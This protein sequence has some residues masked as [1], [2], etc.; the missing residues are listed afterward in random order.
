MKQEE[1]FMNRAISLALNGLGK[2]SP[3]PMVGCVIVYEDTII[4]EGYHEYYGG[5]HAEVNALESVKDKSLLSK[6]KVIV[7]LEPC[8]H[9]GKTPP[10]T[11]LLIRSGINEVAIAMKD[12]NPEVNGKGIK[13]LRERGIKVRTGILEDKAREINR[14]FLSEKTK[15]RPYIILKWA[16]SQ[17]GF[18][19]GEH[20][21]KQIIS[22][23]SSRKLVHKWRTE[24]DA[25]LVGA[26]TAMID[27]PQLT[28]R[29]WD[30]RNPTRI[31]V[32]NPNLHKE[33]YLLDNKV[34]TYFFN[35]WQ[36]RIE[37]NTTWIKI[38]RTNF[39]QEVL[40]IMP[41]EGIQSILV[42]GGKKTLSSFIDTNL[43]DEARIFTSPLKLEQGLKAP[44]IEGTQV[45]EL[46]L[47]DDRLNV[48]RN[49][50][51]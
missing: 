19:V 12:P 4:G 20:R 25:I 23:E 48:V 15:N 33:A 31:I 7:S 29:L 37:G 11:D 17:D 36:S 26:K 38:D 50:H 9:Q 8:S 28:V 40:A 6:S 32:G 21:R 41:K 43:W 44:E 45:M 42:E 27:N 30:G 46:F 24:E 51:G 49:Y 35:I 22:N 1:L 39:L 47:D 18:I 2:V 14:R 10:C 3:N 16:Q 34:K 5:N 13:I